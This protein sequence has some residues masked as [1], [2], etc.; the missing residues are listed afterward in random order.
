MIELQSFARN[1]RVIVRTNSAAEQ[2]HYYVFEMTD[3]A[4]DGWEIIRPLVKIGQDER[5]E[6]DFNVSSDS[7]LKELQGWGYNLMATYGPRSTVV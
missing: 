2:R 5:Q 3:E 7:L 1:G 6:T 4:V